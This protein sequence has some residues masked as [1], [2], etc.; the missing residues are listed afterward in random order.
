M[1]RALRV[2]KDTTRPFPRG[3]PSKTDAPFQLD[4]I[5][6]SLPLSLYLSILE[7]ASKVRENALE[8]AWGYARNW[9]RNRVLPLQESEIRSERR[10]KNGAS[11]P[12]SLTL[13]EIFVL[14]DLP[15]PPILRS[16]PANSKV[17]KI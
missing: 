15:P 12:D 16:L 13:M 17:M 11:L 3:T 4:G 2:S 5:S 1:F 8:K 9:Q 14:Q 6:S 10:R 7:L